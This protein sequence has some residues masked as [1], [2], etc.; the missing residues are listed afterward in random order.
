MPELPEVETVMRGL[1]PV[2]EGRRIAGV[3]LRRAGLRFPFPP[4]FS[5]RLAGRQVTGL[6]RR[7]KYILAGFDSGE[8][9]LVHLGMTGRFTVFSGQQARRLGEFYFETAAGNAGQGPH[10]HV[11]LALDDGTHLVYTDPRRFGIMDLFPEVEAASHKLLS[12]IGVEPLGHEFNVDY[13]A[14]RF[15][16]KAAPLKAA[17]LDQHII[18]G[19]GNIYVCEALFRAGLSP[20]R[21]AR[22]L[23]RKKVHDPRLDALVRH[24]REVLAEAIAAGG[25]TLQD[26]AHTDGAAGAFQQRFL[27]YGREGEPCMNCGAPVE[28]LV[29]SGR[30]TFY[31]RHCQT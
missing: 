4:R 21:K 26:F 17:L 8:V 9:L 23:V 5:E 7:A 6:W 10:D 27:V 31:C 22:T 12:G 18:A 30:S 3:T 25:S 13:L 20:R 1:K 28:R 19:L 29:Q 11:V 2:L 16:G 24:V 15:C 14:A